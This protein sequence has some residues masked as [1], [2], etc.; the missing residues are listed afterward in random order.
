MTANLYDLQSKLVQAQEARHRLLTG[1][2]EVSVSLHGYGST[3]YTQSNIEG[4]ER[5]IDDLKR[6]IAK[7]DGTPR[8][9]IIRTSF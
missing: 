1:T 7:L 4:L 9:T 3:T 5:Y 8:R 6:D 2:M